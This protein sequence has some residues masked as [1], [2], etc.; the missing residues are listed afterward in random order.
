MSQFKLFTDDGYLGFMRD[1]DGYESKPGDLVTVIPSVKINQ[2]SRTDK[3]QCYVRH[4]IYD[5][6]EFSFRPIK[7]YRNKLDFHL[8]RKVKSL[9]AI[10]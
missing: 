3:Y 5:I 6:Y 2:Y 1:R 9:S 4:I 10:W 8:L 7:K